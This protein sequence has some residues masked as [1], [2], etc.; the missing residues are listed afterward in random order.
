[1][2]L[3]WWFIHAKV[4]PGAD[5]ELIHK[6]GLYADR[7]SVNIEVAKSIGYQK[8][9]KQKNKQNILEPMKEICEQIQSHSNITGLLP[10]R[11]RHR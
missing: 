11:R 2:S 7:L 5:P 4:M 8:I 3:I 1:M 9:A 6:T 10:V